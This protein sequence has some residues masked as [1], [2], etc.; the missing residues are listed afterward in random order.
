MH[1]LSTW[2]VCLLLCATPGFLFAQDP[3]YIATLGDVDGLPGEVVQ[4]PFTLEV[5]PMAAPVLGFSFSFV[6]TDNSMLPI[7]VGLDVAMANLNGGS[8]PEFLQITIYEPPGGTGIGCGTVFSFPVPDADEILGPGVH[9]ALLMNWEILSST[10]PGTNTSVGFCDCLGSNPLSS[11]VAVSTGASIVPTM[12]ESTVTVVA[13]TPFI[14]AD[15]NGSGMIDIADPIYTLNY[16]F[17]N[18]PS[19]CLDAMDANASGAV[20]LADALYSLSYINGSGPPPPAPFPACGT[21]PLLGCDSFP[22][23][24]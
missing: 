11:V 24:P 7:S 18:G 12:N 17:L 10:E 5:A 15:A 13:G 4:I 1:S 3:N 9:A 14:R 23:C 16:L 2:A 22:G 6:H 8:G 19:I 21:A 20:D